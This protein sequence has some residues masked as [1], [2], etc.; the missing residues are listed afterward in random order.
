MVEEYTQNIRI[1]FYKGSPPSSGYMQQ[2]E[3]YDE[4]VIREFLV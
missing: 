2:K 4:K 3:I 1:F